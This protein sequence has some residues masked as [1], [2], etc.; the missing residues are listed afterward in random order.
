M[1]QKVGFG[2]VLAVLLVAS[3]AAI[4]GQAAAAAP[5]L[6]DKTVTV[7]GQNIH[8]W[9]AGSGPVVVLVHGLG[10][11]K[12]GDWGRVFGPLSKKYRVIA[13]DQLG[14][15]Q[16]DKPVIDYSI[17][18]YVD[19]LNEF[20][21]QLKIEKASLM[22]ESLGG[23]IS[24]SYTLEAANDSK[25]VP[26]EKLVL[27][28]AAGLKQEKPIPDLNPSTL[29]GMRNV[30]EVVFYNTSWINDELIRQELTERIR[31]NISYTVHSIMTNPTLPKEL[32]DGKLGGIHVPTLVVWGKQDALLQVE[33]GE[34]Y[35]KEI[36]G[37]KLV[38]FDKCGHVPPREKAPE[39]V[40]AVETFLDA[41]AAAQ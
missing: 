4:F 28:D 40:S 30:L 15:G 41:P 19:F 10:S 3:P 9:D 39:F 32:L 20:L 29:A 17:Q 25:M 6:A 5:A 18:T 36:P 27:S 1:M 22:G 8:Y 37:A 33:S 35:A 7:F 23:W 16:S 14:F 24:A 12:E 26:V 11:R 2:V 38:T 31:S 13:L 21:H 34:R